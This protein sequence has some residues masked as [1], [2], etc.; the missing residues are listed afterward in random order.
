MIGTVYLTMAVH[1]AA[2]THTQVSFWNVHLS[3][4]HSMAVLT[5]LRHAFVQHR[6]IDGAVR[7]MA[8]TAVLR[9][10]L[11]LPQEGAAFF[12]MA[13][14]AIFVDIHLLQTGFVD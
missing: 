13:L 4:R 8:I 12:R 1:A 5:Q 10:R 11:M 9:H 3:V 14:I 7:V 6:T 2:A